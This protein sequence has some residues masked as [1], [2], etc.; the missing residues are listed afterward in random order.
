MAEGWFLL[1]G[2]A[3]LIWLVWW[4]GDNRNKRR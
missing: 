1:A 3:V 2:A 4:V